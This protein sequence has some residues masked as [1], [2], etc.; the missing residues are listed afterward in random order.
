M[1][2]Q[3][4]GFFLFWSPLLDSGVGLFVIDELLLGQKTG[5]FLCVE[6][7]AKYKP[8]AQAPTPYSTSQKSS[9]R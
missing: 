2:F 8:C 1:L 5:S 9:W 6:S 3:F 7:V 4:M